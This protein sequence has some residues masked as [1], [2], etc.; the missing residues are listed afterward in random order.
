LVKERAEALLAVAEE[1]NFQIWESLA[2]IQIGLVQVMSGEQEAGLVNVE[3]GFAKYQGHVNP[4]VFYPAI[5]HM[6][7]AAFTLAGQP[8]DALRLIDDLLFGAG[9]ERIMQEFPVLLLLKGD[10]LVMESKE[11]VEAAVGIFHKILN[12]GEQIGGKYLAL[13]AAT[14]LCRMEMVA[15]NASESCGKLEEIYNSFSEGFETHDLQEAKAVLDEWR[16]R[17]YSA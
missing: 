3:Q 13:Q 11:N 12:F 8:S 10:L 14:R 7:A 9:G 16:G 1:H 17:I 5:I 2:T 4:P 6:R 15:G